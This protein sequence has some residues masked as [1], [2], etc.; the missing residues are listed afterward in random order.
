MRCALVEYNDYHDEVLPS[1]VY[2]LNQLGI[3]PDVFMLRTAIG[4]NAFEFSPGLRWRRHDLDD[5]SVQLWQTILRYRRYGLVIFASL[6]PKAVIAA[7]EAVRRPTLAVVHN[8]ELLLDDPDYESFFYGRGRG[9]LVLGHHISTYLGAHGFPT[10]WASFVYFGNVPASIR[11][12]GPIEFGVPG[13]LEETRRNYGSLLDALDELRTNEKD[14][15][16]RMIGR[17]DSLDAERF[18]SALERR[19]VAALVSFEP[20]ATHGAY[21]TALKSCDFLLPLVDRSSSIYA[22][23]YTVKVASAMY[24]GIGLGV[25]LVAET[26]VA[27]TYGVVSGAVTYTDGGLASAMRTAI[28]MSRADRHALSSALP[29]IREQSVAGALDSLAASIVAVTSR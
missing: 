5:P 28:A 22:P 2:L 12:N 10:G 25:P 15:R 4:R 18:R 19:D 7:A 3:E 20:Q 13:N 1:L 9:P 23:Y 29:G 27:A 11:D 24:M 21:F 6:E 14:F 26:T 16:V 8:A 17:S